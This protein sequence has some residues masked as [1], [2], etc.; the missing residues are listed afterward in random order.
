MDGACLR[1]QRK[2]GNHGAQGPYKNYTTDRRM[3]DKCPI[4][5]FKLEL[6]GATIANQKTQIFP[7]KLDNI[8]TI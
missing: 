6:A 4:L 2:Q 1:W 5:Y 3:L 8:I 7:D